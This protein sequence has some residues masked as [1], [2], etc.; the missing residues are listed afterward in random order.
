MNNPAM[1]ENLEKLLDAGQDSPMLRLS[2]GNAYLQQKAYDTAITHFRRC[3]KLDPHYSAGWK[4]YGKALTESQQPEEA[5]EVYKEGIA[6]AEAKGDKQ[7][8]KEMQVFL[9]RL[10]KAQNAQ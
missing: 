6:V 5:I 7:A 2:L 4:A 1:V 9:K 8:A 3:L 10:E